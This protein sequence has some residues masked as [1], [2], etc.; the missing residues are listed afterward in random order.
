M[1][2]YRRLASRGFQLT[3]F[4]T[5]CDVLKEIIPEKDIILVKALNYKDENSLQSILGMEWESKTDCFIFKCSFA[6]EVFEKIT[7]HKVLSI[8]SMIFD[9]LG[10]IQ[11]FI[12]KP[13]LLIQDLS[14][15]KYAW[16]DEV[17]DTVKKE[18]KI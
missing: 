6:D 14:R 12:L 8:Y 4:F 2:L 7:C 18:L 16:D 13:K 11:P 15:L 17:L 1:R 5:N 9:P 10:F 3:K